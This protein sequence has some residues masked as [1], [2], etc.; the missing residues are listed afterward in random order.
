L[1]RIP[2][3]VVHAAHLHDTLAVLDN[4]FLLPHPLTV[5]SYRYFC[6]L[7]YPFMDF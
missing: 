1:I 4:L 5:L 3:A 2:L 6:W 7:H